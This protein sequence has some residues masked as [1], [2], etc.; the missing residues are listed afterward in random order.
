[1]EIQNETRIHGLSINVLKQ[2]LDWLMKALPKHMQLE[3]MII[4][5]EGIWFNGFVIDYREFSDFWQQLK[6]HLLIKKLSLIHMEHIKP[7]LGVNSWKF[8]MKMSF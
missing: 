6:Q 7:Y 1:M 2:H 5:E 8:S 4:D 3:K